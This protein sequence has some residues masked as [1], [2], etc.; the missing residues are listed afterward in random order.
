MRM[1]ES[2]RDSDDLR[3]HFA[4]ARRRTATLP[5]A[6][7]ARIL[8]DAHRVQGRMA[9]RP[10]AASLPGRLRRVVAMLG[11]WPALGGLTAACAAGVWLGFSPPAFLPDPLGIV[12][13][14]DLGADLDVLGGGDLIGAL[15]EEG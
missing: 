10:S 5:P 11:G 14:T 4:A 12:V 13:Q 6:L 7:E 3:A 8:A 15:T 9:G 1:A 2:E